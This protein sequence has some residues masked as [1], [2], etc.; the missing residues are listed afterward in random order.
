VVIVVTRI[1]GK[2]IT[3]Y[4][5]QL[6]GRLERSPVWFINLTPKVI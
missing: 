2:E 1:I 4:F 5:V 3:R 6:T